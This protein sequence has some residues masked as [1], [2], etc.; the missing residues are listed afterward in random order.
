VSISKSFPVTEWSLNEQSTLKVGKKP[1]AVR[2][3]IKN[4]RLIKNRKENQVHVAHVCN[5][6]Y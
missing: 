6:S 4:K 2:M 3:I 5:P 1:T